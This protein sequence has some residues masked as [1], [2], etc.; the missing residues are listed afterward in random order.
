M[1]LRKT[2]EQL[3]DEMLALKK[4][5]SESSP[6]FARV[7]VIPPVLRGAENE[8]VNEIVPIQL[9][10]REAMI[11]AVDTW[12]D[13]HIKDEFSQKAARRASGVLWFPTDDNSFT[14][15]LVRLLEIINT[16]KSS[17]E[18]HII[19]TFQ[20]RTSRFEALHNQCTGVLTL[21]LYR[22]IRWWHD[23]HISAVR[24]CW[25]EKES[26]LVPDKV[27]LLAR[28]GKDG[29]EDESQ[30]IP[31]SQLIHKVSSVPED[32]LRIRRRLKVQPVANITFGDG[33]HVIGGLKTV[34]A[35]MPYIIIQD[36]RPEIKMLGHFDALERAKRKP[37][38]DRV[39][40]EVIG[41]FH[42][43]SIEVITE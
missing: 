36:E 10:G 23:Q 33:L 13:L 12:L 41:H 29:R 2:F 35:P 39:K 25:Q 7:S 9:Y 20:T 16:L 37:R 38:N 28:M 3:T 17:M 26:L 21:H 32:K 30:K 34:T 42:G 1:D 5:I 19:S 15:E 6:L 43:E 22:Q 18:N 31:M 24:F 11:K 40:T 4:L 8:P 27:E 14:L